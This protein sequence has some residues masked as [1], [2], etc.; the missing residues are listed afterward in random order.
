MRGDD[1]LCFNHIFM[2]HDFF[3]AGENQRGPQSHPQCIPLPHWGAEQ[4][5]G[6]FHYSLCMTGHEKVIAVT[7]KVT[8]KV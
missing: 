4:Q 6:I 3:I 5:V 2:S 8:G 1:A 7:E